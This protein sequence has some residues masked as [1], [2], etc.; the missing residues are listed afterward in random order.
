MISN[1]RNLYLELIKS[2][3]E[4]Y[5]KFN[6]LYNDLFLILVNGQVTIEAVESKLGMVAEE[7]GK[8]GER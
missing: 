2:K 1:L 6:E 4:Y 5:R 8:Y 3:K 7:N